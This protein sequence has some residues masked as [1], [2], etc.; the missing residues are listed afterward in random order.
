MN[1][2]LAATAVSLARGQGPI[3][4]GAFRCVVF[5]PEGRVTFHEHADR[6][7]ACAYAD[8]AA[9]ERESGIVLACVFDEHF[10]PIH[11]GRHYGEPRTR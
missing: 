4:R 9:S 5:E 6:R 8:D 2:K 11:E 7:A 3:P 1:S 10:A